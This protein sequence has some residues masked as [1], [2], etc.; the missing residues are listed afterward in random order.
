MKRIDLHKISKSPEPKCTILLN[1]SEFRIQ[2]ARKL[3]NRYI[4]VYP[5][6]YY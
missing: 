2:R 5:R 3:S 4:F 6:A 1:F